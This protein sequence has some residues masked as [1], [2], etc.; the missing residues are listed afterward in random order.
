MS[1]NALEKYTGS[2]L[3]DIA[4]IFGVP[5]GTV[6]NFCRDYINRRGEKARDILLEELRAGDLDE[7]HAASDDE[8]ISIIYRYALAVRDGAANRNLRLL[9]K[10]M[11]GLAQRDRLFSDEF[12]KYVEVLS[13]LSRDQIFILGRYYGVFQ[14]EGKETSDRQQAMTN[15]WAT[16]KKAMVPEEFETEQHIEVILAQCAALGILLPNSAIGGPS[17]IFSPLMKEITELV[18]FQ[19]ALKEEN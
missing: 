19:D 3:G 1:K 13:R 10:S 11:V 15:S 5:V 12:N 16:L 17:Y 14:I 9:A 7:L 4:S 8:S 2:I 6:S 18:K